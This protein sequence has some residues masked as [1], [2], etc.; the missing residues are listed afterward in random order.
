MLHLQHLTE[1]HPVEPFDRAL[2]LPQPGSEEER[3]A[4]SRLQERLV[5]Q[6]RDVFPDPRAP[7]TVV[8]IPSLSMNPALL[9]KISGVQYY[10]E[11]L[12]FML[13]LLRLPNT[14]VVYVTSQPIA[15]SIIDYYLNLL[16]GVPVSHARKRLELFSAYDTSPVPLT[17]K[18]LE[19]PRLVRRIRHA[20]PD[21]QVAHLT[22][23]NVTDVER[24]L[25][26]WLDIPLYGCDPDRCP[27]GTKSGSRRVF[28]EAGIEHPPG[29]EDVH[30]ADEMAE[31][32]AELRGRHP[33]LAKAVVKL[34][35]GISGEGNA[36]FDYADAPTG[37]ALAPWIRRLLPRRLSFEASSE[38]WEAYSSQF[39]SMGGVVEA[40]IDGIGKRSP[41]MQGG[42]DPLGAISVVS[43]HDQVLGGPSGQ[44]FQGCSFPADADYRLDVQAAGSR[45]AEV[46]SRKGVLGRFS[47]DFVSLPTDEGWRHFAVEV[48]LRKG[49]TTHPF[50]MLQYL[51]D[52]VFDPQTGQYFTP[53]GPVRCYYASDNLVD[54]RYRG[55]TPEDLTDIAVWHGLHFHGATQ[56]GVVFHLIGALSQYGKLGV[57]CI[58]ETIECARR[59][60]LETV[61]VLNLEADAHEEARA[62]ARPAS[63]RG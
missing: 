11:R 19:R 61:D 20:I 57:L 33:G 8:V 32:L 55:F 60:Y 4:F 14:R 7:R 27:I 53:N 48:N 26:V 59:L 41:S 50:M 18:L 22:V 45:V 52:G 10:E 39:Q 46:L 47:V 16:P 38:T 9:E 29:F 12:L 23:Y 28:R 63:P 44:I 6:F 1:A 34:D 62:R 2:Q 24:T 58:A 21:R 5:T 43:T 17:R 54:E 36:T 25:A 15:P 56:E 30:G 3:R 13:M 35:E 49:G 31:A 51:T 42:V 40:Y 37:S